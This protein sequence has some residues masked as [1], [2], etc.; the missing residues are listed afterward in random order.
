[1]NLKEPAKFVP[2][3]R[4]ILCVIDENGTLELVHYNRN[5][6]LRDSIIT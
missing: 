5:S 4:S 3:N 1:M 6:I 2:Y